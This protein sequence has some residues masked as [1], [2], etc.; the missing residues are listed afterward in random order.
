MEGVTEGRIVHFVLES[1]EHRPAVIVN[2]WHDGGGTTGLVNLQ[3]ILDGTNDLHPTDPN[4]PIPPG[5][6][7]F[8]APT[9]E[10]C[11]RGTLWRTSIHYSPEALEGT[12]HWIEKA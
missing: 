4:K 12:W 9:R 2:A 10:D 11:V 8:Q 5:A 6:C 7:R 3:V 1:G